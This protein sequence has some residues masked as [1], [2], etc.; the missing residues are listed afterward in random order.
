M[1]GRT[2]VEVPG[3]VVEL[4]PSALCRVAVDG[5]R[6]IVAHAAGGARRNFVRLIVGDR[7]LVQVSP[8]DLGRGRIVRRVAGQGTR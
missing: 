4:L 8:H 6:E 5:G 7:V 3:V 2:A 1:A